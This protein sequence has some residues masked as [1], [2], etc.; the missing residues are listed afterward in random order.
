MTKFQYNVVSLI[1]FS[2]SLIAPVIPTQPATSTQE[3]IFLE[4]NKPIIINKNIKDIINFQNLD[5]KDKRL[6]L[7][8]VLDLIKI[9]KNFF[10][11]KEF[12]INPT[13]T[14]KEISNIINKDHISPIWDNLLKIKNK[15]AIKTFLYYSF[16]EILNLK[17][18]NSEELKSSTLIYR[19]HGNNSSILF[20]MIKLQPIF[21]NDQKTFSQAS[22]SSQKKVPLSQDSEK[23]SPKNLSILTKEDDDFDPEEIP[24]F[25]T[26]TQE[27]TDSNL[28]RSTSYSTQSHYD[29]DDSDSEESE[30][31]VI[32]YAYSPEELLIIA[33]QDLVSYE[34]IER[35]SIYNQ[36]LFSR[37]EIEDEVKSIEKINEFKKLALNLLN[38]CESLIEVKNN[39]YLEQRKSEYHHL[40][41]KLNLEVFLEEIILSKFYDCL[42][43][44][45]TIL[46]MNKEDIEKMVKELSVEGV[47]DLLKNLK[48]LQYPKNSET[49]SS[50]QSNSSKKRK[51]SSQPEDLETN[52]SAENKRYKTESTTDILSYHTSQVLNVPLNQ[53]EFD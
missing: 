17:T 27:S 14:P 2:V 9:S 8:D 48:Y 16:I 19:F 26:L 53:A 12:L 39:F 28:C 44:F 13:T 10:V 32:R 42:E 51:V 35:N 1:T 40:V 34:C 47:F 49:E 11:L 37:D 21:Q 6:F 23:S 25:P 46:N 29:D 50:E 4:K 18:L 45:E 38:H 33:K 5:E 41:E 15:N 52:D 20:Y 7:E 30:D 36:E 43:N 24:L 22:D 31:E 3:I